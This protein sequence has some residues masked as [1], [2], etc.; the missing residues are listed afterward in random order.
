MENQNA[1]KISAAEIVLWLFALV[2]GVGPMVEIIC[3]WP[4]L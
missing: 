3:N 1:D 4:P 2:F